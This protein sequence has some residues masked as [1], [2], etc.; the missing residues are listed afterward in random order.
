MM[1]FIEWMGFWQGE[2]FSFKLLLIFLRFLIDS[3]S[4]TL[5]QKL[6]YSHIV[7]LIGLV[8]LLG[9]M[10]F[11]IT[12]TLIM[13]LLISDENSNLKSISHYMNNI[14]KNEDK[15]ITEFVKIAKHFHGFHA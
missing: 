2:R 4:K 12:L 1:E 10:P 13:G 5:Q 6:Q 3:Y 9:G 7:V 15:N 14:P 8:D 11:I